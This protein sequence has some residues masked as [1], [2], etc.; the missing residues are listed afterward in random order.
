ML[1][2]NLHLKKIRESKGVTQLEL[3]TQ[4]GTKQ[5]AIARMEREGYLPSL[6]VLVKILAFLDCE[7]ELKP[8]S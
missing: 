2:L 5:P 1:S 3:A 7:L 4:V 6:R 8:K